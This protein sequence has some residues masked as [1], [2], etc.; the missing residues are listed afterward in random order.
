MSFVYS[1][2][3]F[4]QNSKI[5]FF[6]QNIRDMDKILRNKM[7]YSKEFYKFASDRFCIKVMYLVY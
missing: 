6:R 3:T 7:I 5:Q 4:F 2:K 1:S